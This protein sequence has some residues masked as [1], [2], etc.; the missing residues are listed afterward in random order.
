MQREW[1]NTLY[2]MIKDKANVGRGGDCSTARSERKWNW[3]KRHVKSMESRHRSNTKHTMI[4]WRRPYSPQFSQGPSVTQEQ[5]QETSRLSYHPN[6]AKV[7]YWLRS[8]RVSNRPYRISPEFSQG[9]L[10]QSTDVTV[11]YI[12]QTKRW[13]KHSCSPSRQIYFF[14]SCPCV[15]III[16]DCT[17]RYYT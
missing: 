3:T 7:H 10:K 5:T 9:P 15:V 4:V 14:R 8:P 16:R 11:L 12:P 2:N 17:R 1:W 6:P 13:I